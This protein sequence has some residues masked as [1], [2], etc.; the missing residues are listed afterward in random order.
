[1]TDNPVC[2]SVCTDIDV[3]FM[4]LQ[5]AAPS[6]V[7]E[8]LSVSLTS[9]CVDPVFVQICN[10]KDF[11][12]TTLCD[13]ATLSP[14]LLITS[15]SDT[16]VPTVQPYNVDGTPYTGLVSR[17]I[18]CPDTDVE[19]DAIPMCD[20]ATQTSFWRWVVKKDG[21]PTGSSFDTTL[22]AA[23]YTP[24][25]PINAGVCELPTQTELMVNAG[26][27][28]IAGPIRAST[29]AFAGSTN[30]WDTTSV[31]GLLH[32]LTVAA[33]SVTDGVIGQ[34]AN[35]LTIDMPDGTSINMM[36]GET[37]T[38]SVARNQDGQLI[39]EYRIR[40]FGNSYANI[41]YTFV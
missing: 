12:K 38:F 24:T 41:T 26:G 11:D 8:P 13:P 18:N 27:F 34:T 5:S 17:L 30:I 15:Y 40:A 21:V 3:P 32:S 29:P 23:P 37:R 31:P 35:Q 1:M 25:G 39:R 28:Q 9:S 16:G 2:E 20:T 7:T 6:V 4:V 14:V 33:R 22:S 10:Q 19:S 36:N